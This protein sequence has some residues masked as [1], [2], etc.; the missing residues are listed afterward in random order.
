ME[1]SQTQNLGFNKIKT[2]YQNNLYYT[3][4]QHTTKKIQNAW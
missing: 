4:T 1:Q 3:Q 2:T